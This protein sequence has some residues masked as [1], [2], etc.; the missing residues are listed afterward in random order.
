MIPQGTTRWQHRYS[1]PTQR[2]NSIAYINNTR[3]VTL[4]AQHLRAIA[5]S[6]KMIVTITNHL[7]QIN[8]RK[9]TRTIHMPYTRGR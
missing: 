3:A 7:L 8:I 6:V 1:L 9:N 5:Y 2:I 4:A